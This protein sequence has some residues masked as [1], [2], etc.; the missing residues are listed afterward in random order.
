MTKQS[1]KQIELYKDALWKIVDIYE[2]DHFGRQTDAFLM[3]SCAAA[4]LGKNQIRCEDMPEREVNGQPSCYYD[5]P[6]HIKKM[7]EK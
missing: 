5:V 6:D 7:F 4:V 2:S 1:T 3:A